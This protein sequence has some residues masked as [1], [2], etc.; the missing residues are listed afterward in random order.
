MTLKKVLLAAGGC[1]AMQLPYAAAG[2]DDTPLGSVLDRLIPVNSD[3]EYTGYDNHWWWDNVAHFLGG[4]A[5]GWVLTHLFGSHRRTVA[6]FL[7]VTGGWEV[8][9]YASNE[10][11]WHTDENGEMVWAWDHAMEDTMLDTV[12]GAAGAWCAAEHVLDDE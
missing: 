1:L 2:S 6:G 11:P 8:F 5:V 7:F 12:A 4:Y 10:R 3:V 9:E